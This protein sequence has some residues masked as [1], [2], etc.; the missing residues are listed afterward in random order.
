MRPS[1]KKVDEIISNRL[2][3]IFG[4]VES[5]L[6]TIKRDGL[7]PA[8]IILTGGGASLSQTVDAAKPLS[9]SLLERLI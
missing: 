2:E 1:Q 6:K 4:L 7:L 8:G 9:A 5:H 3:G